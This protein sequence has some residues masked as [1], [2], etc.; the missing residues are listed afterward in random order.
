MTQAYGKQF[1]KIYNLRWGN[2]ARQVAPQ[3][4]DFYENTPLGK[5]NKAMLDLCCGAGHLAAI[6]LEHGYRVIGIDLSADILDYARQNA[7]AYLP[8]GK[9]QFIQADAANFT[10]DRRTPLVVSTYDALNHLPDLAAL[11]SCFRAV[12]AAT[13]DGGTF[14]FDLNT[15]LGLKTRWNSISVED[16]ESLTLINRSL[17]DEENNRA[18]MR[19]TGFIHNADGNY[20]RFEET[21]FNTAFELAEVKCSLI[22]IGWEKVTIVK[23]NDFSTPL[24]DPENE[25]RVFFLVRK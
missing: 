9:A 14:I 21:V 23:A 18:W 10:I 11:Q 16:D 25:Y 15:R 7:A 1:S 13:S 17:F 24:D 2:F 6:F 20:D 8:Q 5:S 22:D 19:I 12:H 4:L 3:I